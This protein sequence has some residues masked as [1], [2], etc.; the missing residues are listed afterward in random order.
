[1]GGYNGRLTLSN[2]RYQGYVYESR[3]KKRDAEGCPL[4]Q[5]VPSELLET[6]AIHPHVAKWQGS[7]SLLPSSRFVHY[8]DRSASSK[9]VIP[10]LPFG[11]GSKD[12]VSPLAN[13]VAIKEQHQRNSPQVNH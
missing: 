2:L 9:T 1:M 4:F 13:R 11:P 8:L 7:S 3:G 5:S 10:L 6:L 12:G